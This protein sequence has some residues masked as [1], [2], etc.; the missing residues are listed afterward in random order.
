[1]MQNNALI[2]NER[3]NVAIAIRSIEKDS[4]VVVDGNKLFLA[5][6]DIAAS[7]KVALVTIK[8]GEIVIR[9]GEPIV[10]AIVDIKRGQWVHVHNTKPIQG[11]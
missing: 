5:S 2:I 8:T 10:K 7:H 9:Y 3:D 6:Q 11:A 1:M 4:L